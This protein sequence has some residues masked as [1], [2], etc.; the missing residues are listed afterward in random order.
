[1]KRK[2]FKNTTLRQTF[3]AVPA[4][5]LMLGAAQAGT[6]V[7]LNFNSYYYNTQ[8]QN[9]ATY[10]GTPGP[11]GFG[12]GYQTSGWPVTGT[13]FGVAPAQWSSASIFAWWSPTPVDVTV[14]MGTIS[15]HCTAPGAIETGIGEQ[16]AGWNPQTV[17]PGNDEVTWNILQTLSGVSP[18][19]ALSGLAA[20]YPSGYVV[21]TIAASRGQN[22][23][24]NGVSFTDGVNSTHAD[25]T[26]SYYEVNSA[27]DG[28]VTDGTVAM[29]AASG[30]FTSDTLQINCDPQTSG[31]NSVLCGF[32][33]TDK[34]VV[35]YAYPASLLAASGG[36]FVLSATAIGAGTLNYQ[37]QHAGTN[38]SGA[39]FANYTNSSATMADSGNYQVFVTSSLFPSSPAT[40]QTLAVTVIPTHAAR[41]ATWDANT[42]TTGAQDGSGMWNNTTTNWWSGTLDDYWGSADSAV[43]GLGGTGT[44]KVTLGDNVTANAITFNSAG[45]TITNNGSQA[46]TLQG[47]CTLTAN[48][49]ATIG[50]PLTTG[51]NSLVKT[52]SAALTLSGAMLSAQTYVTAGSLEVLAKNGDSPY[53]VTNGATLKIGYNTGGGYANT[54]MKIYG[55]GT[56]ATTGFYLKG[57]ATYN[58][59]GTPTL[60]GAPTTIRQYGSGLASLGIFDINSTGLYCTAPASGSIIDANVQMVNYGY[61]MAGQVDAGAN[62]AI[63]KGPLNIDGHNG[64]YGFVKRGTGSLRLNA[65]AATANSGLDVRAGSAICGTNNCIGTNGVL[66][67]GKGATL[68]FNGYNQTV[69]NAV[70]TGNLKMTINK[71]GSPS[72]VVLTVSGAPCTLDGTLT[73]TNLGAALAIGDT[74][75]LFAA[76]GGFAGGFTTLN[77][78]LQDGLSWQDNTMV[79]GTLKVIAGSVPPTITTDLS[80]LTNYAYVGGGCTLSVAASGDPTL[81]YLWLKNGA[82]PVGTDSPTLTLTGLTLASAGN[83]AA[84]VS[85]HFGFAQ[86]QTNYLQVVP[87]NAYIAAVAQDSPQSFWPLNETNPATA[88]EYWGGHDAAQN[89]NV[90]LGNPGPVPPAFIGFDPGTMAYGFDGASAYLDCGTGPALAG[91]TDF[92]LE[93]WANTASATTGIIIQQRYAAGFN[94]EYQFSLTSSGKLS[95]TVYGGD[96]QFNGLTSTNATPLNDGTWHHFAA[97]RS[98]S[99]GYLYADGKLVGA[100]TGT[101]AP[102]DPTFTVYIGADMRNNNT[103]FNGSLCDVAIYAHALSAAQLANHAN[104]GLFGAVPPTLTLVGRNLV[105]TTGTLV[106]SPVLGSAAVWTPVA[107]AAS[108]YALPPAGATSAA[109]FYRV[110][111]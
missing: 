22:Q 18:S 62:T 72:S 43:F 74:F 97:V 28:A 70:L 37:W 35:M 58:V 83:Y 21:A 110:K 55:D 23:Y 3:L 41:T 49:A 12:W 34:P 14:P 82:T 101:P 59:S 11:A 96:Y 105:W 99:Y 66:K 5:A 75:T 93:A 51:T 13:A 81:H 10:G 7:A 45:Y 106:S 19:V 31:S 40:G 63:L 54:G 1:M 26:T 50:A 4:A 9:W 48:A 86:S 102:L 65:V 85:N 71:G 109:L 20:N 42:T 80:G 15:A 64:T 17:A 84:T 6:T 44:Y 30:V 29:S 87:A 100:A 61:G 111:R 36:S 91:T 46:I 103:W 53:V 27:N 107:G 68:D 78:P 98:G 92:T 24:F 104:T 60:L 47:A 8:G 16:V 79:D 89:G 25:Y 90:I 77:L 33:I 32:I 39:T 94:G 67:V 56:A 95:F 76:P 38:L 52:G 69:S 2:L 73:V 108:P 57:G 88:I